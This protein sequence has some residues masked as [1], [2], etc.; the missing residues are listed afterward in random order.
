M[1]IIPQN[2]TEADKDGLFTVVEEWFLACTDV[3][4]NSFMQETLPGDALLF[5]RARAIIH[6]HALNNWVFP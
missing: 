2:A 6:D 5:K 3:E 4:V 1:R